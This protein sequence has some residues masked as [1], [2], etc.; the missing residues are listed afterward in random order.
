VVHLWD[1]YA[2]VLAERVE[3]AVLAVDGMRRLG[4]EGTGRASP[5]Y[6]LLLVVAIEEIRRVPVENFAGSA[7][8]K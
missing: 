4:D 6:V 7:R 2:S 1:G 5:D 3:D 8:G